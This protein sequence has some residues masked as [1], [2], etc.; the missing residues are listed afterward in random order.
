MSKCITWDKDKFSEF[1]R[2]KNLSHRVILNNLSRC[3]RIEREL[4]I[5]LI[6]S[7]DTLE[8]CLRVLAQINAY[9]IKNAKTTKQR[10]SMG[11]TLRMSFRLFVEYQWGIFV[12]KNI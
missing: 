8:K 11:G 5:N 9:S 4:S 1:L 2:N 6:Q 3:R 10:Y 12:P 7:S